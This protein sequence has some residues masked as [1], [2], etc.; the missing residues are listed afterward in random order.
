[1]A[2]HGA[3]VVALPLTR[4]DPAT[5]AQWS[6]MVACGHDAARFDWVVLPSA[7]AADA[8]VRAV[9]EG[10][11]RLAGR[12]LAVGPATQAAAA[13]HGLSA[14][15]PA[16]ADAV[17]AAQALIAAG[18]KAVWWPRADIGRE[19]GLE[20][21]RARGI[22]VDAP[23][24]YRTV[25]APRGDAALEAGL[26]A[27]ARAG[28]VCFYAPSHVAALADLVDLAVL[29]ARKVVAIGET[30]AAA[31]AARGVRVDAVPASPEPDA[32]ASAIVAV[33]PGST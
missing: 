23:V 21:L 3:V 29:A 30:T 9:A 7:N 12:V 6:A 1:L 19:E 8:M 31:L 13:A 18:A 26:A 20:L 25:A 17:G 10:G 28:V 16:R 2:V 5:P 15:T 11:G 27:L 14:E 22:S 33:Y 24:A 4:I 32:M